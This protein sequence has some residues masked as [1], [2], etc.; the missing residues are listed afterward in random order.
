MRTRYRDSL[1][2]IEYFS[3]R[4][5]IREVSDI[6]ISCFCELSIRIYLLLGC[7]VRLGD[8]RLRVYDEI[9]I[10]SEILCTMPDMDIESFGAKSIE[11]WRIS[12]V[13]P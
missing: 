2:R 13:R 12:S 9:C 4:D 10:I 1:F 5:W 8:D 11:K 3:E 6:E 7:E